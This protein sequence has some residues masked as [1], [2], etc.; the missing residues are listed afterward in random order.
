M[1]SLFCSIVRL[2][3]WN[4]WIFPKLVKL[5]PCAVD[6]LLEV[7][8]G[9]AFGCKV[10]ISFHVGMFIKFDSTLESIKNSISR[11]GD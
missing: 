3:I 5:D 4:N 1:E 9:S 11:S 8:E 7:F 6:N 2:G 10:C